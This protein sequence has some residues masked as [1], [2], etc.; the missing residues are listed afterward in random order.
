MLPFCASNTI[1]EQSS[2]HRPFLDTC[3]Q[4]LCSRSPLRSDSVGSTILSRR[5]L[6]RIFKQPL[7][8]VVSAE[9]GQWLL[10]EGLAPLLKPGGHGAV[11]KLMLDQGIF[12]WLSHHDREG[13]IVRQIRWVGWTHAGIGVMQAVLLT[14][15]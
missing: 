13:A 9:D 5:L 15:D 14:P 11:W 4:S 1:A 8:P 6:C 10:P 12:D 7:V 2:R 3:R